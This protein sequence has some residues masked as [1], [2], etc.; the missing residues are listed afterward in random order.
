MEIGCNPD[1]AAFV[2]ISDWNGNNMLQRSANVP[3]FKEWK[4]NRKDGNAV[5]AHCLKLWIASYHQVIQLKNLCICP[6]HKI[7]AISTVSVG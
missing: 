7:G 1:I 2:P 6:F 4:V 5:E 3:W